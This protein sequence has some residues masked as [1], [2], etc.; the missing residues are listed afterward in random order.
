MHGSARLYDPTFALP[1][2]AAA[3][4]LIN[5]DGAASEKLIKQ[6]ASLNI[7]KAARLNALVRRYIV[8]RASSDCVQMRDLLREQ[9]RIGLD[10]PFATERQGAMYMVLCDFQQAKGVAILRNYA[11]LHPDSSVAWYN[12]GLAEWIR[13]ENSPSS[14]LRRREYLNAARNAFEA[15]VA[16][17][18]NRREGFAHVNLGLVL[19]VLG[20][21]D[22]AL[23]AFHSGMDILRK[24]TRA[25][26]G[27]RAVMHVNKGEFKEA[28][29]IFRRNLADIAN[30]RP[31]EYRRLALVLAAMNRADEALEIMRAGQTR[32]PAYCPIY[33]RT[34]EIYI[35]LGRD[36]EAVAE[37]EKGIAAIPKCDANYVS[38]AKALIEQKR[39]SEAKKILEALQN[40]SPDS[41]GTEEAKELLKTLGS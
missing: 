13:A 34:G 27:I 31:A 25:D 11:T 30:A 19:S 24:E 12:L 28:E 9:E 15:G 33:H 37:W 1:Y 16:A 14:P 29:A 26:R 20:E 17:D 40:V 5:S 4:A 18:R 7:G 23:S 21:H 32:F 22:A 2:F 10:D 38:L 8:A 41:D 35:E 39:F 36:S 6:T 3:A